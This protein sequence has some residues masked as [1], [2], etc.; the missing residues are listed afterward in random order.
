MLLHD[1]AY[2]YRV[3]IT[4]IKLTPHSCTLAEA[5]I[6]TYLSKYAVG[7]YLR[8]RW[9]PRRTLLGSPVNKPARARPHQGMTRCG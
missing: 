6:C 1:F 4:L 2:S 5:Q 3:W 9:F 8:Y 7:C